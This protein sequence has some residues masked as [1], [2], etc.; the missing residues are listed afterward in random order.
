M[1]WVKMNASHG[2]FSHTNN[3]CKRVYENEELA[4][5]EDLLNSIFDTMLIGWP[6]WKH[7]NDNTAQQ[8]RVDVR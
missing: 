5:A 7:L 8:N 3:R 4:L 2:K 1:L 6:Q